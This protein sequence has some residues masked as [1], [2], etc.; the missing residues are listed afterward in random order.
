[1]LIS[2]VKPRFDLVVWDL[3]FVILA[4]IVSTYFPK[5]LVEAVSSH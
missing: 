3:I 2:S 1:M 5:A 4:I